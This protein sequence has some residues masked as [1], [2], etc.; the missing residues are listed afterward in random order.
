M[1]LTN[2]LVIENRR[3]PPTPLGSLGCLAAD[4]KSPGDSPLS[5]RMSSPSQGLLLVR[6]ISG[7]SMATPQVAGLAAYLWAIEPGLTPQQIIGH[8]RENTPTPPTAEGQSNPV[9]LSMPMALS[10]PWTGTT[11]NGGSQGHPRSRGERRTGTSPR[12]TSKFS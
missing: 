5:A 12:R 11:P 4:S 9:P 7:T 1:N 6:L 10:L 2:T 3:S 8:P